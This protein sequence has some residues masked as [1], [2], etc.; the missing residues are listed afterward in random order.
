MR[1]ASS[2]ARCSCDRG[3]PTP[4]RIEIWRAPLW[5]TRDK[6]RRAGLAR[7]APQRGTCVGSE[8]SDH[9]LIWVPS[10]IIRPCITLDGCRY[11]AV[12]N[13]VDRYADSVLALNE[14]KMS[15]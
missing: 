12:A 11:D 4:S 3:L 14:L 1:L 10:R 15:I 13:C 2:N 8:D 9:H 7:P 6:K 5:R